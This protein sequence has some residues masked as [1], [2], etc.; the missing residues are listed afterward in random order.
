MAMCSKMRRRTWKLRPSLDA[1][2]WANEKEEGV[3]MVGVIE[4]NAVDFIKK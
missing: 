1:P 4:A 3:V 2:L